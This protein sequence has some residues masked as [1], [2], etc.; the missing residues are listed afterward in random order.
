MNAGLS[1]GEKKKIVYHKERREHKER[2]GIFHHGWDKD[3]S[4]NRKSR[5]EETENSGAMGKDGEFSRRAEKGL[6]PQMDAEI[7]PHPIGGERANR[8]ALARGA[9]PLRGCPTLGSD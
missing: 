8:A 7:E 9:A 6:Q 2:R 1:R 3:K 5:K 4:G